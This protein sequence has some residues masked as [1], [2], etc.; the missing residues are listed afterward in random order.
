MEVHH[1]KWVTGRHLLLDHLISLIVHHV[2]DG[3]LTLPSA[4]LRGHW[5]VVGLVHRILMALTL[6][7]L[8]RILRFLIRIFHDF[9]HLNLVSDGRG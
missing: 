3:H 7:L 9:V 8:A 4:L 5:H 2:V 6:F 1:M